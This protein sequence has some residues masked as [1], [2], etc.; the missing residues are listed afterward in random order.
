MISF[1]NCK[2]NI[3]L[4]VIEKR[5]DGYH[6]IESVFYP[7]PL[8]DCLEILPAKEYS[9]NTFGLPVETTPED[10]LITMAFLKIQNEFKT[11][12]I[13]VK[14]IKNIPIGSGLGGGSS[15]AAFTI[16]MLNSMFDL[17][18]N[19]SEMINLAS[20]IGSDCP[21]FI[22]NSPAFVS[23]KGE[24]I[25]EIDLNLSGKWLLLIHS[26]SKSS[27]NNAYSKILPSASNIDLRKVIQVN[28]KDWEQSGI[29]NQFQ[30]QIFNSFPEVARSFNL[31]REK[32]LYSSLTGSGASIYGIFDEKSDIEIP[33]EHN[34]IQLT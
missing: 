21:F 34:W 19:K 12:N 3:G 10:N 32:A 15:N 7:V 33:S 24:I 13:E 16:K 18:L 30:E 28:L 25:E 27:T 6:N 5:S 22:Q 26:H 1:P 8:Y 4:N 17:G 23:G 11:P 14:L 2:I 9:I 20:E 31:I 29:H